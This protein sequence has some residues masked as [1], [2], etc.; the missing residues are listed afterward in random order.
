MLAKTALAFGP[1]ERFALTFFGLMIISRV[2]GNSLMRGLI[3]ALFGLLI[4]TVGVDP[5]TGIPRF[6]FDTTFLYG[7]VGMIE[8]FIGIFAIAEIFNQ[9]GKRAKAVATAKEHEQKTN[10][11]LESDCSSLLDG[12]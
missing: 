10:A 2:S 4:A 11:S 7:G 5:I 6:A 3:S 12:D 8:V 1:A 9:I